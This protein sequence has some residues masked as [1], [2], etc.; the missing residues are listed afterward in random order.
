MFI[1][2]LAPYAILLDIVMLYKTIV[3]HLKYIKNWTADGSHKV[4]VGRE[5]PSRISE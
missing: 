5:T 4:I 1:G 3:S 2:H